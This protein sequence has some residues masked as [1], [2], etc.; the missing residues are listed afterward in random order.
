MQ[1]LLWFHQK[2]IY[3]A[4]CHFAQAVIYFLIVHLI[5]ISKGDINKGFSS[6]GACQ[7][8]N[9]K[10]ERDITVKSPATPVSCYYLTLFCSWLQK[11]DISFE[12]FSIYCFPWKFLGVLF[13]RIMKCVNCHD[14]L[15]CSIEFIILIFMWLLPIESCRM[16]IACVLPIFF[17][18]DE[19]NR[20]ILLHDL[21]KQGWRVHL[22]V[23]DK[24]DL[25]LHTS[26]AKWTSSNIF[27]SKIDFDLAKIFFDALVIM[28]YDGRVHLVILLTLNNCGDILVQHQPLE[29]E[30]LLVVFGTQMN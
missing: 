18:T 27:I 14:S 5:F 9:H 24:H 10:F 23:V 22:G 29:C 6:E 19:L 16:S 13:G 3:L 30:L 7:P 2:I 21:T 11:T 20:L 26:S 15:L 28:G 4:D 25:F 17:V 8:L 12:Q 1:L